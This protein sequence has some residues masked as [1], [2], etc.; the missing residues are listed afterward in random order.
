VTGVVGNVPR[1]TYKVRVRKGVIPVVGQNPQVMLQTGV[2]DVP[3]GSDLADPAN[4]KA[5]TSLFIG[6]QWQQSSGWGDTLLSA[7]I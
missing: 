5:G 4:V 3:A 1:N 6:S 2:Y 7:V